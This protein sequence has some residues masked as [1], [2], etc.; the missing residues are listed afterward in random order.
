M[1][2]LRASQGE[3]CHAGARHG[4]QRQSSRSC[5]EEARF[6]RTLLEGK[7]MPMDAPEFLNDLHE[8]FTHSRVWD[9]VYPER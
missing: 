7:G 6:C 8:Q 2:L 4:H 3:A 1:L 9:C 5:I